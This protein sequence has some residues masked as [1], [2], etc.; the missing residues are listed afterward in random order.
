MLWSV[1]SIQ[2]CK[3]KYIKKNNNKNRKKRALVR[4][5]THTPH[6]LQRMDQTSV[7][8]EGVVFP[9]QA[10]C[11]KHTWWCSLLRWSGELSTVTWA[12]ANPGRPIAP[13]IFFFKIMQFS[14]NFEQILG[15]GPHGV[16]TP[17]GLP[18]QNPGSTPGQ[19]DEHRKEM[20]LYSRRKTTAFFLW[21]RPK[22]KG[23]FIVCSCTAAQWRVQQPLVLSC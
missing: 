18:D 1:L 2:F 12:Q 14:G 10:S 22:S 9:S 5:Q 16:K 23:Y 3:K 15:L 19:R 4:E 11:I 6:C 21:S 7:E 8:D 13:K 17:L 20:F